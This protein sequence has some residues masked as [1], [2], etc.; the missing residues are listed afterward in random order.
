MSFVFDNITL[1]A[2]TAGLNLAEGQA[3]VR[4][5]LCMTN[6]NV[7]TQ[8]AATLVNQITLDEMDGA[9]Y[10]RLALSSQSVTI[11]NPQNRT[12]FSASNLL[13][14]ALG[15][16]TRQM[17]GCLLYLHVTNDA[18]SVPYQWIDD[19][20][21]F[22]ANGQDFPITWSTDGITQTRAILV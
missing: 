3:D 2:N 13:W 18:D 22:T 12:E 9:N 8:R 16:G 17:A 14:S 19:G 4:A 10:V 20:F 7:V 5:I 15:A 11:N 1:L 6:T 21:P